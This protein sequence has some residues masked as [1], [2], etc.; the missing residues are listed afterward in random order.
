MVV[1]LNRNRHGESRLTGNDM[2][3]VI[4]IIAPFPLPYGGMAIQAEKLYKRLTASG[5]HSVCV[6]SNAEFPGPLKFMERLRGIRT[7]IRFFLFTYNLLSIREATVIHIFG[8]SYS[9]FFLVVAPAIIMARIMGKKII[10]NYRGGEAEAFFKRWRALTIPFLKTVD[11]ITVPSAFLKD[12]LEKTVKRKVVIMPNLVDIE[13][14]RYKER[15]RLKPEIVVSRQLEPRY[16]V[17][18]ALR[19]FRIVKNAYPAARL[20]IAGTGCEEGRL[21]RMR[22]ELSLDDVYFL[23][24]LTHHELSHIYNESDILINASHVDNFPASIMEAFACGLPVVT[25]RVGGIPYM[26]SEGKTGILVDPDDYESLAAGVIRL[27]EDPELAHTFSINGRVMAE[28]YSW[29]NIKEVLFDLY[30]LR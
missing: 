4:A 11:V 10:L 25:T 19:A 15:S 26:V 21:K 14:F 3:P 7:A 17:A 6:K 22:G 8:A 27:M 24:D 23:G 28:R 12:V 13:T 5:V 30:S 2:P 1:P 16:N 18:C 20:K 29:E 9:Y